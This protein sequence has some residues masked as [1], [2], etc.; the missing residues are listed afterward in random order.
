MEI[1]SAKTYSYWWGSTTTF[2]A[3]E[4]LQKWHSK[5]LFLSMTRAAAFSSICVVVV[6]DVFCPSFYHEARFPNDPIAASVQNCN[7]VPA[8]VSCSP[9]RRSTLWHCQKRCWTQGLLG[10][11]QTGSLGEPFSKSFPILLVLWALV[12]SFRHVVNAPWEFSTM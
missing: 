2:R 12:D 1:Q 9:A 5:I 11:K 3:K 6:N 4:T 7:A 8:L 10:R